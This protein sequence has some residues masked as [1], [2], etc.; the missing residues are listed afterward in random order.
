MSWQPVIG[1]EGKYEVSSFGEVRKSNGEAVG[2]WLNSQGYSIVRLS[3]PRAMA[4]V[5]RLVAG[6]F[7]G[8]ADSKPNVN[9]IDNDR[10]NN[11]VENLEWCTQAE[12]LAHM[13]RQGR[14]ASPA[15]N[16]RPAHSIL[17][18]QQVR[19]LRAGRRAGKSLSQLG[20][21]FGVSKRTA[22]R[23]AAG[24]YYRDVK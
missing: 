19:D 1:W 18:D 21:E 11:K 5:H 15:L 8:N 22:Q 2:Q 6:A 7:L 10:S 9:H 16:K 4:R 17:S 23:C 24:E 13:S 20:L 14:R 3:N 12:N